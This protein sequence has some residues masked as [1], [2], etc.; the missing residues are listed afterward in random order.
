MDLEVYVG[1]P[2]PLD[3]LDRL[4][5]RPNSDITFGEL[6]NTVKFALRFAGDK[7]TSLL[8]TTQWRLDELR[9]LLGNE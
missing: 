6:L 8:A 3:E 4:Y 1:N 9:K 2:L 5:H 7:R